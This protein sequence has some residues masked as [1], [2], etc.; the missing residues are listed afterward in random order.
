M[1]TGEEPS[2]SL[3][4]KTWVLRVS[5]H[6]EGCKKKVYRILKSIRGVYDTDIDAGQH[7]VTVKSIVDAETLIRKLEKSG[8][9]AELWPEKK[10]S[11]QNPSNVNTSNK[12][13]GESSKPEEPSRKSE[14]K[15]IPSK[16]NPAASSATDTTVAKLSDAEKTQVKTK[17]TAEPSESATKEPQSSGTKKADAS[18]QQPK[19]P[20]ATAGG[21]AN[22]DNG[23]TK[24]KGKKAQKEISE[25][26]G[27][28]P[29]A[30]SISSLPPQHMY[31]YPTHPP[32]PPPPY[33]MSYNMAE[34]SVTQA[35]YVSPKP[36]ASD[37]FVYMPYPPPPEFYHGPSDPSS[38]VLMQPN[39]FSDENSNSCNLM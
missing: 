13:S 5:I 25:E 22:G 15:P 9:H 18:T 19:K 37:G 6:C 33:V 35:Y 36:P 1:A 27:K 4:C 2:E 17:T 16:P 8:K 11:N 30:G 10:P 34:P 31:S 21:E 7:K 38:P 32:P 14:K 20:A 28:N 23:C 39:M 3:T 26:A 24:K 12:E 29:N